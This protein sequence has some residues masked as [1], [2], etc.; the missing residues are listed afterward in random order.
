M[1]QPTIARKK[2][3]FTIQSHTID[4]IKEKV[5][6]WSY[7]FNTF[8]FLDNN[9]YSI[10]PNRYELLVAANAVKFIHLE[11]AKN[12]HDWIF[13]QIDFEFQIDNPSSYQ[14]FI[15]ETILYIHHQKHDELI[16]ESFLNPECIFQEILQIN[17]PNSTLPQ[18]SN[19]WEWQQSVEDYLKQIEIIRNDIFHGKYYELNYCIPSYLQVN[20]LNSVSIFLNQKKINPSPFSAF[21]KNNSIEILCLSPERFLFTENKKIICQPI[22]GTS[23][24]HKNEMQDEKNKSDLYHSEK[25]RAENVMIVDLTRNDLCQ[26]C[27]DHT[28]LVPELF[29]IYSFPFV[30]QMISTISGLLKENMH[31]YEIIKHTFPMGSMTGAPKKTVI[32]HITKYEKE[33]RGAYSGTIFY[34]QPNGDFDSNVVI[35]SLIYKKESNRLQFHTGG[36]ITFDSIP[37]KEWEE[38]LMKS[39]SMLQM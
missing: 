8:S 35:R 23:P 14:A 17:T 19:Q 18:N 21:Y 11:D 29:G 3:V 31:F 30:H 12:Q 24:R 33:K 9:L 4:S 7:Q 13:G 6:H 2:Q 38:V 15:P 16:I 27:E 20:E 5:L 1:N 25:D 39:K 28:V 10:P 36:A 22:K 37:E 32:E 26:C 34:I